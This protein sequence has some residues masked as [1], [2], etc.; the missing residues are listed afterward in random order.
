M[1]YKRYIKRGGKVCGP[2]Y[3]ES[4]RDKNGRVVSKYLKGYK[5]K[6]KDMVPI[7]ALLNI[8][9]ILLLILIILFIG[10][11]NYGLK[12]SEQFTGKVVDYSASSSEVQLAEAI[13][14]DEVKSNVDIRKFVNLSVDN[15]NKLMNFILQLAR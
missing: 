3:Y 4:H 13:A 6:F 11:L 12:Y 7:K 10:N 1:V 15:R 9:F 8:S 2:Y 5:P 14:E